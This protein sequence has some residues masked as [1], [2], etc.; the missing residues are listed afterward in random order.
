MT[1]EKESQDRNTIK[2]QWE[3]PCVLA[4][5]SDMTESKPFPYPSEIFTFEAPS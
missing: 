4:L 2:A 5:Q 3:A 1:E